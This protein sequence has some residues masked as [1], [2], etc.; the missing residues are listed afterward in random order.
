MRAK[1]EESEISLLN[2]A[3]EWLQARLPRNWPVEL[4][5]AQGPG[6]IEYT[7]ARLLIQSPGG[8]N[9][10]IALEARRSLTPREAENLLPRLARILHSMTGNAPV[11]I[12]APWLSART[13]DLLTERGINY[14]DQTGN[15]LVRLE[16]PAVYIETSGSSRNPVPRV[17][18]KVQLR[19]P[20]AGRLIRTLIDVRPP[21]T[22]KD[23]AAATRLVPGYISQ[24]LEAL[25]E[26]ALID[27]APR[28]PVEAVDVAGLL[29]RWATAYDVF[30]S[31]RLST[32]IAPAGTE[33]LLA[34]LADDPRISEQLVITGSFAASRL[35][36][37]ASP[38]MLLAYTSTPGR[39]A[40]ELE[41]LP[42]EEGANVG[43][44][45]P[46]DPVV[47][48]RTRREDG[49][50]FAAPS[51]VAVDCLT[52]NGRMPAEGEA[53][54]EWMLRGEDKWRARDLERAE[55]HE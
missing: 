22:V 33:G 17:R 38:A 15:A 28:G 26:E 10:S 43:L 12:V 40:S 24:L 37:I 50:R 14:I 23:L 31:N 54:L 41:L 29:R 4:T 5:D 30:K 44:L 16:N 8:F 6:E 11:L 3:V 51:Q 36:P 53:L 18:G 25:N 21:Y 35:A 9:A 49:L 19:G 48:A 45:S 1:N 42:A 7:D 52:G 2:W 55:P 32:Y 47:Q 39:L 34:W 46:F 13:R 27:R 20:K